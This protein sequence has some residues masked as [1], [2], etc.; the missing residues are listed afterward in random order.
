MAD[1][2][3]VSS[4]AADHSPLP[5]IGLLQDASLRGIVGSATVGCCGLIAALL[6]PITTDGTAQTAVVFSTILLGLVAIPLTALERVAGKEASVDLILAIVAFVFVSAWA[7]IS[8][9]LGMYVRYWVLQPALQYK[10][11]EPH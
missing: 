4:P 11:D 9:G 3:D 2:P 5:P 1:T 6:T 7:F 10:S 8:E